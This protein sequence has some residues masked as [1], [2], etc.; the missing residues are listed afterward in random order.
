MEEQMGGKKSKKINKT[1]YFPVLL[2]LIATVKKTKKLI[3]A[4]KK[5]TNWNNQNWSIK[6]S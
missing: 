4:E 5:A 1:N 6:V 3:L 2:P